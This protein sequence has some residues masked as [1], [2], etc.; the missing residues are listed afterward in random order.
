MTG[1]RSDSGTRMTIYLNDGDR[2][3]GHTTVCTEIVRRAQERGLACVAVLHG[4]E[5]YGSRRTVHT[6]RLLDCS[7]DLPAVIVIVDTD[8]QIRGFLSQLEDL[9]G[10]G[11][12]T[13]EP[14]SPIVVGKP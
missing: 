7:E 14:V 2:S 1:H 8:D 9:I 12:V 5:G 4:V 10:D 11:L 3:G 6:D 13:V